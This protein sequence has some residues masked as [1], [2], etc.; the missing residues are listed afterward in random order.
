MSFDVTVKMEVFN[1]SKCGSL[2]G[3]PFWINSYRRSCPMCAEDNLIAAKNE[4]Y[5]LTNQVRGLKAALTR[6]KKARGR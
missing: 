4:I 3:T 6:A 1:C 2:Y 5:T